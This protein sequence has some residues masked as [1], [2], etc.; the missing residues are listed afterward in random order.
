MINEKRLLDRF[1]QYIQI[2]SPTKQE[3]EFA[4]F[5][6]NE[7][8]KIGLEVY[9]DDAGE[10]VG[11]NSGNLIGKLRGNTDGE[12]ILFSARLIIST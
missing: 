10:K 3:R 4:D 1:L 7:M 8:E 12:S 6:K 2:D 9:M 11:S 5:L